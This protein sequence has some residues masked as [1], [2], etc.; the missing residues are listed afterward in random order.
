FPDDW[1]RIARIYDQYA[2]FGNAIVPTCVEWVCQRIGKSNIEFT[3]SSWQRLYS[4]NNNR[5]RKFISVKI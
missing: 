5:N 2:L 1:C 4:R 3:K